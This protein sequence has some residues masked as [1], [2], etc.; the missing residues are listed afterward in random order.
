LAQQ[1]AKLIAGG[2]TSTGTPALNG[3][4]TIQFGVPFGQKD[5][6]TKAQFIA[7]FREFMN[8]ATTNREWPLLNEIPVT[9]P[10][11]TEFLAIPKPA[12]QFIAAV[13]SAV[14]K[15]TALPEAAA[16]IP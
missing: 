11:T 6:A 1:A 5:I 4:Y 8:G 2:I 10:T 7:Q 14:M 9:F 16:A 15:G 12:T 13:K 3:V